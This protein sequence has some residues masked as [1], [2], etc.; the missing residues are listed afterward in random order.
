MQPEALSQYNKALR[1]GQRYYKAAKAK[2]EDPYLPVLDELVDEAQIA[3]RVELGVIDIPLRLV[4]GTRTAGRTTALAGNFMPLLPF[5]SEFGTKWISL[6]DAHLEQAGVSDPVRC[7]EY[8]GRF[9]VQEGNKRVSVMKSFDAPF[10]SGHVTRL[11]PAYRP[12][13]ELYF[14]FT[15]FYSLSRLYSVSLRGKGLYAELQAK[16]G[17]DED[18]VWTEDQR[19]SFSAGFSRFT[20]VFNKINSTEEDVTAGEALMAWLE[21]Y[22]FQDIKSLPQT[23][24]EHLLAALWPDI[25]ARRQAVTLCTEPEEKEE[26]LL[27]KFLNMGHN[28]H[29]CCAF[30]YGFEPEQSEWT[31]AHDLGR[32]Y[33]E[34]Q[35]GRKVTSRVYMAKDRDFWT[36]METAVKEGAELIFATMPSMIDAG[37]RLAAKYSDVK[38]LVCA[39]SLPYTG[40]RMYYSRMYETKF[41]TGA[42][43]GAMCKDDQIGFVANFPIMGMPAAINAFAL[44]VRMTAPRAKVK[45]RWSCNESHP[46]QSLIDSGITVI[47]NRDGV[48]HDKAHGS[49]DMGTYM[50]LEDGSLRSLALPVWRWGK[51]Y[52]HIV[53]SIFNGT[54]SKVPA[55]KA[56]NYWWGMSSGAADVEL[57]P[58]LPE[59]V[60]TLGTILKTGIA[61]DRLHPFYTVIRD[62]QGILRNDGSRDLTP[63]EVMTMDWL[64]DNVSGSIPGYD[65]IIPMSREMV[66]LLGIYR[67]SIPPEKDETQL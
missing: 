35:M 46:A 67:D 16:L 42:I 38:V 26:G 10:I 59:G 37:R 44:G 41:I 17:F 28:E 63:E 18:Q 51:L 13:L 34:E 64:C 29:I 54:W 57:D 11:V 48:E 5:D 27:S 9:Y 4:R 19:R 8:L 31:R 53:R 1:Q 58:C 7:F 40:V 25:L 39:L 60:K 3:S 23:E 56:I 32:Q 55:S 43:A 24:L 52:E 47:S 15:K 62:Q 65:Q 22:S 33:L 2:G 50:L 66:R 12:E 30:I 6:C 20:K 14:E 49:L 45:L 21:V 61:E 36:P